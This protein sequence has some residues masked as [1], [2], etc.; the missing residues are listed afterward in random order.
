MQR[1]IE[2][3]GNLL[4]RSVRAGGLATVAAIAAAIATQASLAL[5]YPVT[6]TFVINPT[7]S[8]LEITAEA[9]GFED[10]ETKNL[11]GSLN[12]TLDLGASGDFPAAGSFT[13]NSGTITPGGNYSL[14][15]GFPPIL[16]VNIVASGLAADV[17]TIQPPGTMT[18]TASPGAVYNVDASQFLVSINQGTIVVSGSANETTDLSEEPVSGSSEPGTMGSLT[19]TTAGTSG[20]FT[21]IDAAL[22]LPVGVE[23]EFDAEGTSGT[24]TA[25]GSARAT[26]SFYVALGGIAGDFQQDGDVDG[27]DLALWKAGYGLSSGAAPGDGDANNDGAVDGR[28]FLVWQRQFG[29]QP[30][31]IAAASSVAAV[32]EP[33]TLLAG[34]S[35]LTSLAIG[36]RLSNARRRARTAR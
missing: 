29:I 32:P 24:V 8:S 35:G 13:I 28:D 36:R 27:G 7:T 14:R 15:L 23:R 10:S 12:V 34:L 33:A 2:R 9:F 31:A 16:G 5:G 17:S 25:I 1:L 18:R 4:V 26:A 20:L 11:S 21:R 30:P 6:T 22:T 19:L 3:P